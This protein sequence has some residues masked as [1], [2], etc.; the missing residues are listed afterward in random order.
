MRPAIEPRAFRRFIP[1]VVLALATGLLSQPASAAPRAD[2]KTVEK[3]VEKLQDEAQSIGE[4]YNQA[5]E[6]LR[7]I[8]N[9]LSSLKVKAAARQKT[10]I[11]LSRDLNGIIRNLYKTGGIDLDIQAMIS[12]DPGAFLSR[13]DAISIVGARQTAALR[14]IASA[15]VA[16]QQTTAELKAEQAKAKAVA[17]VAADK[18]RQ[19][20]SKLAQAEKLLKS[21]KA[22]ERKKYYSKLAK[23]KRQQ[24]AARKALAAKLSRTVANKRIR[25]VIAWALSR[26]G[27]PYRL[28]AAGPR[29]FDCSGFTMT[30]YRQIGVHLPHYSKAQPAAT[31]PVSRAN[32][33]PGD[34]VFFFR[35]GIRH[36]GMYIGGGRMVHAENY[37]TGIRISKLNESYYLR[38]VSG[39]GRVI[40]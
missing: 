18:K 7:G 17:K 39:Y 35:G 5:L 34:L 32:L 12:S 21:L 14:R 33:R 36:I 25:K 3:Q 27:G 28:G 15:N 16:L 9:K 38:H 11:E 26:V 10:Y 29:A 37:R 2:L 20:E 13:L 22:A 40:G 6:E 24:E 1:V 30:A 4:D 19:V 31:R 8:N 23:L